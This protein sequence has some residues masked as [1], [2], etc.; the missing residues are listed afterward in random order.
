MLQ[1]C[2]HDISTIYNTLP[3]NLIKEI[4]IDLIETTFKKNG[5]CTLLVMI[6]VFFTSEEHKTIHYGLAR[7]YFGQYLY[8]VWH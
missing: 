1:V 4:L 8:Q 2:Q 6:D 5:L 7:Q 3:H